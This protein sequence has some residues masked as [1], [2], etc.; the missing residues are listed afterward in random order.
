MR[1]RARHFATGQ[2]VDLVCERGLIQSVAAPTPDPPDR[3]A[4][5]ISPALFDLQINGCDGHSFNS[6]RLTRDNIRHVVEVCRKHGIGGLC[7]TLVTAGRDDLVHGLTTIARAC[8]DEA[9]L[10]RALPGI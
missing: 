10:D 6:G 1:I 5:W 3:E 9:D 7:P 2:L 8:A 4:G